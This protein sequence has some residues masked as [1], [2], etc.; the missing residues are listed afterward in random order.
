MNFLLSCF[1]LTFLSFTKL[2][3]KKKLN[4]DREFISL[5][6]V[7]KRVTKDEIMK[8]EILIQGHTM[9]D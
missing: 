8:D 2:V 6:L 7:K 9:G 5:L 4:A 1:N 3:L